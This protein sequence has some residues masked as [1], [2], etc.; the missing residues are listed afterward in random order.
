MDSTSIPAFADIFK[1]NCSKNSLLTIELSEAEVDEIFQMVDRYSGLEA[2]L[3]L[4]EQRVTLHL[5]EE[6]SFHFEIDAAIKERL[7]H[8]L[9]DIG[10]TLRHEKSITQFET[11]H[12]PQ[13][14][15]PAS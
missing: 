9:D 4:D 5:P 1:N 2:T 10:L 3:N 15:T 8:G 14:Y 13:L 7:I 6:I 12:N 11:H